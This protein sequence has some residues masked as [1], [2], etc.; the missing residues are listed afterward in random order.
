M[1]LTTSEIKRLLK[2]WHF[3]KAYSSASKDGG[4]LEKQLTAIER[5]INTLEGGD[6]VIIRMRYIEKA[7]V[8]TIAKTLFISRQA[9]YKRME[10]IIKRM[11]FCISHGGQNG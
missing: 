10:N 3:C 8:D 5:A 6:A 1:L 9:V 2:D 4:E 11:A 7:E